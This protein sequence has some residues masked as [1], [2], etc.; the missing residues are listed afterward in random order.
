MR[1]LGTTTISLHVGVLVA[2]M[3]G[4]FE[5]AAEVI[6]AFEASCERYGVR[7][8]A[9]PELVHR[10]ERSVRSDSRGAHT[11]RLRGSL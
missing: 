7:P 9:G 1:D 10:G 11:G 6:G 2:A 8:P 3:I 4:R 5:D